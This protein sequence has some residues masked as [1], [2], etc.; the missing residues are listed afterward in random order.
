MITLHINVS[1]SIITHC[2]IVS[3]AVDVTALLVES[4]IEGGC[5]Y[6]A[7]PLM[8]WCVSLMKAWKVEAWVNSLGGWVS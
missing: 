5:N 6:Y 8:E 3:K 2:V 7:V 4:M 1:K